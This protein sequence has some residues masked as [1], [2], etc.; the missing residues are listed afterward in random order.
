MMQLKGIFSILLRHFE[1]ELAQP[2][3]SYVD[4][5]S[6]MVVHLKQPCRVRYRRRKVAT[7]NEERAKQVEAR[8]QEEAAAI[9][10]RVVVDRDLCQGH[11]VCAGEA[12]EIF[13]LGDDEVVHVLNETPRKALRKKAECAAR[14][15]PNHV[16]EIEDLQ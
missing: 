6:K 1:F 11:G 12:P 5:H 14:Y 15:C 8:E 2:P 4:N 10:F 13:E 7:I 9:P 16:I 3:E